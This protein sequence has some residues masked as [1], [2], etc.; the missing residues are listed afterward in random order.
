M[1]ELC[2]LEMAVLKVQDLW[3][4]K[5]LIGLR[6]VYCESIE[7]WQGLIFMM[8]YILLPHSY[9]PYLLHIQLPYRGNTFVAIYI[10]QPK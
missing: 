7:V 6:E 3:M 9:K 2:N 1:K 8:W 5:V 10:I 4:Q